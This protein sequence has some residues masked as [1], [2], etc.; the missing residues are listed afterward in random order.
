MV[1]EYSLTLFHT[2]PPEADYCVKVKKG[3]V[4]KFPRT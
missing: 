1:R 3:Y 2:T 4:G